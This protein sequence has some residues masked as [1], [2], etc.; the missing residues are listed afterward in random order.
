VGGD[1]D[2]AINAG[3]RQGYGEGFLRKSLCHPLT[4]ANTG[5]NTPTVIHTEI[6]PGDRLKLTVV[7]KGGGSENMSPHAKAGGR[8]VIEDWD[9]RKKGPTQAFRGVD[10]AAQEA[11]CWP[12]RPCSGKWAA[13]RP[14][15][16]GWKTRSGVNAL[17]SAPRLG[18][19]ITAGGARGHATCHTPL[20]VAVNI[21]P[22]SRH[23][24][25]IY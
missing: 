18:G 21:T 25:G 24:G 23:K 4:R 1:F 13:N 7:P 20:P 22:A 2:E 3:I 14:G 10:R 8:P 12:K 5:D 19:R 15:T 17:A 6:V 16:G 11:A 9:H